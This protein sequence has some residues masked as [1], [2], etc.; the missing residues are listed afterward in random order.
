MEW[1]RDLDQSIVDR[2]HVGMNAVMLLIPVALVIT[3]KIWFKTFSIQK[4][5]SHEHKKASIEVSEAS[6]M[7]PRVLIE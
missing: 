3:P 4:Y 5:P 1:F 2:Q 6:D 7:G